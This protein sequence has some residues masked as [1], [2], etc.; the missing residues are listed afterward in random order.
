MTHLKTNN[1]TKKEQKQNKKEPKKER[2]ELRN[3]AAESM[4][5]TSWDFGPI[6]GNL[7]SNLHIYA[8]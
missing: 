3:K 5:P 6:L 2:K 4:P 7:E 1:Q 8:Q